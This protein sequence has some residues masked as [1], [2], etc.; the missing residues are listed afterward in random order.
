MYGGMNRNEVMGLAALIV[1][2]GLGMGARSF[3]GRSPEGGVWVE[4]GKGKSGRIKDEGG[5]MK[6]EGRSGKEQ[7]G[8][9]K[10]D[11]N[12]ATAE[13]LEELP[14]VGPVMARAILT[15]RERNGGFRGVEDLRKVSGV[16]EKTLGAIA[17][18]VEVKGA[19]VVKTVAVVEVPAASAASATL[20]VA[21]AKAAA[22]QIGRSALPGS[23]LPGLAPA[24]DGAV[25][26]KKPVVN[27]NTADE[28]QLDLLDGIGPALAKKVVQWRA[29]HGPFRTSADLANV[30]G[31]GPVVLRRN[32]GRISTGR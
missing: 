10:L 26:A 3:V 16:G 17:P 29:A 32:K 12:S 11:L 5:R 30:P 7:G 13:D 22:A 15:Y 19:N 25:Q 14:E 28:A 21:S 4:E 31:I 8:A 20:P 2:V 24:V 6:D 27:I 1:L 9:G 23:A 18:F